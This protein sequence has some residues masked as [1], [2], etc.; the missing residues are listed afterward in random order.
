MWR[1]IFTLFVLASDINS[2]IYLE[3]VHEHYK[4]YENG[5]L[6]FTD[7]D[8]RADLGKLPLLNSSQDETSNSYSSISPD[9]YYEL[10]IVENFGNGINCDL[11]NTAYIWQY[12]AFYGLAAYIYEKV[13]IGPSILYAML[14]LPKRIEKEY[15]WGTGLYFAN[16][17]FCSGD[18][19]QIQLSQELNGVISD[20]CFSNYRQIYDRAEPAPTRC[21]Q[22]SDSFTKHLLGYKNGHTDEDHYFNEQQL[23]QA[24]V[25]VGVVRGYIGY[26][27]GISV[28]SFSFSNISI[29]GWNESGF[30]GVRESIMPYTDDYG[31]KFFINAYM[32]YTGIEFEKEGFQWTITNI[33]IIAV[34]AFVG[35]VIIIVLIIVCICCLCRNKN[36]KVEPTQS[37][38]Y[39]QQSVPMNYAGQYNGSMNQAPYVSGQMGHTIKTQRKGA[40]G[41]YKAHT[42]HR[43][44]AAQFRAL[45]Y[46]ERHGYVKGVVREII[47]DPGRGAPLAK[48]E[49]RHTYR[50]KKLI[51]TFIA[52][53]SMYVGQ[54][55]YCGKKAAID[56]GNVLPLERLPEGT[57]I[58]NVESKA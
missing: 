13:N 32:I 31:Y 34:S 44:G 3:I 17:T 10:K 49:F 27:D 33:I 9:L 14:S 41:L 18:R 53:E 54:Y 42:H 58:C 29:I 36:Q 38:S 35:L 51:Q 56:I 37:S 43:K 12:Y 6:L 55:V 16:G 23:K 2:A 57:I 5:S 15:E 11:I 8:D 30:I 25:R 40:G 21:D 1:L 46:S 47:H 48:V 19:K 28:P 39:P 20:D 52:A 4:I 50:Y 45:D 26:T 22:S 24:L 7:R